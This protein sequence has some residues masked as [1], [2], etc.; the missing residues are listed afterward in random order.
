MSQIRQDANSIVAEVTNAYGAVAGFGAKLSETDSKVNSI[1]SWPTDGGKHNMAIFE[2]KSDANGAYM[3]LAAVRDV[4]GETIIDELGGAKIVLSDSTD[5]SFIQMDADHIDFTAGSFTIGADHINL[6][7]AVTANNNV[8][9]GTDGKITAVDADISGKITATS[10]DL[11]SGVSISSNNITNDSN[12]AYKSDIP[13]SVSQLGLDTSTIVY[14]GDVSQTEKT[15]SNGVKYVE[16]TVG[17]VKYSTYDA[18]DY[19]VFGRSKGT[20]SEGNDYIAVSKDGLLTARNAVI[21]GTVY[22]TDGE[23][24]GKVTATS[25]DLGENVK[26]PSSSVDGIDNYVTNNSL[27]TTLSSYATSGALDAYLKTDDLNTKL[28]DLKVAYRGDVQTSQSTDDKTGITTTTSTYVGSDGKTYTTTTYTTDGGNYVLLNKDNQ[29][30]S[31]DSLVK[32]E[33]NGLLEANNAIINGTVYATDGEFTGTVHAGKGD[34]GGWSITDDAIYKGVDDVYSGMCV[35]QDED[36]I[37]YDD[38]TFTT[39]VSGTECAITGVTTNGTKIMVPSVIDGYTVTAFTSKSFASCTNIEA[40]SLPFT[41][42]TKSAGGRFAHLGFIF[43]SA[44]TVSSMDDCHYDS[45]STYYKYNIP[46]S[47]KCVEI[48]DET[49]IRDKAFQGCT[50]LISI[51]IPDGVTS[52]GDAAFRSCSS[53]TNIKIPNSVNSIGASAFENCR[54]LKSVVIPDGVTSIGSYMFAHSSSIINVKIPDSVTSIAHH[55]FYNCQNIEGIFISGRVQTIADNVFLMCPK[56]T[57]YCY[58]D[59]R[60]SGWNTLW[61][62]DGQPVV[63]D[64]AGS[65]NYRSLVCATETS[66]PRFFAGLYGDEIPKTT[67]KPNFLVL[68]DG[69]LYASAADISGVINASDGTFNGAINANDGTIGNLNISGGGVSYGDAYSL[70]EGGL[71]LNKSSAKISVVNTSMFYDENESVS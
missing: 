10:L 52:I 13:T 18:N 14:K 42:N 65:Y 29:W 44:S 1:A 26:V 23:F 34:I 22:A 8:T 28:G 70:N 48:R 59:E 4:N 27:S 9:I 43:S 12:F 62:P 61:N 41:G 53:T 31:G 21:Y 46:A 63:W 7:G 20:N 55:A 51:T 54:S 45:G 49:A 50:N 5:G 39:I 32:I 68:E 69:S 71:T 2:Q 3:T 24:S 19:I 47:L 60:P 30:G 40:I 56:L 15:D 36:E 17:D 37:V 33:K 16:T 67:N 64:C 66:R 57:I 35:V 6:N 58:L 11:G 25:L 38:A